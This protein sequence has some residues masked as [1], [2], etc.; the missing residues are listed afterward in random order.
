MNVVKNNIDS[1]CMVY[2]KSIVDK[3]TNR[4]LKNAD[5]GNEINFFWVLHH[6]YNRYYIRLVIELV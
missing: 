6:V 1:V 3:N 5:N 4:F 2:F